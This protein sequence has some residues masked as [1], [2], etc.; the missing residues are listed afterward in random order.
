MDCDFD[1][2]LDESFAEFPGP[3]ELP[4]LNRQPPDPLA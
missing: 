3:I 4:P 2:A 1:R